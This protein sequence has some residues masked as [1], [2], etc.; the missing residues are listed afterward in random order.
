V[1]FDK[2]FFPGGTPARFYSFR[3]GDGL[4]EFFALD[5]IHH[6]SAGKI[7]PA[8]DETGLQFRWMQEKMAGSNA[9]WKIPYFR[10]PLFGAGPNHQPGLPELR[11][12]IDPVPEGRC[13]GRTGVAG[14][15]GQHE[16]RQHRRLGRSPT[17]LCRMTVEA[18]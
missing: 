4:A 15:S 11:H 17:L 1:Y 5:S 7:S 8:S 6:K 2:F 10:N 9:K 16:R 3:Y 14:H 18:P 12:F 13:G